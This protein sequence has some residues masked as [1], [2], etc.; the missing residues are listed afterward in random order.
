M[1]N[2]DMDIIQK[3]VL[4]SMQTQ[5][6]NYIRGKIEN[7]DW[8]LDSKIPS[9]REL[10]EKMDISRTTVRNAI[11]ALTNRGLFERKIGQ[12]TFVRKQLSRQENPRMDHGTLGFVICK[13][14]SQRKPL[15]SEAFY[16]DVFTGV[17][18]ETVKAGRHLLFTYLDDNNSDEL[19]AFSGFMDKIDGL[20][21][22]E[23]R[24]PELIDRLRERNLPVV[25]IGPTSINRAVDMVT[26]DLAGGVRTAVQALIDAGHRRIGMINGPLHL[27]SARIRYLA[28]QEAMKKAGLDADDDFADDSEGW[29]PESGFQA[30]QRL[31]ARCPD[32]TALVCANDL[33]AIGSLS[34]LNRAGIKVP[35][36][37]SVIGFDDTELAR[38]ATPPLSSMRIH[39]RSMAK[40]AVRRVVELIEN[41]DLP[42][43]EIY[44]P[45]DLVVRES[46]RRLP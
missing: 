45:I 22:E 7:N 26:M 41:E 29:T 16:F 34:A 2:K 14:R 30:T 4:E 40:A 36:Q 32:L 15:A 10:S 11:Q 28:W 44:F 42:P 21:I 20:V 43:V 37:I 5:V 27:E 38:H 13:E 23:A 17:E 3:N 33:L 6:E 12:G 25:L 18:E 24:S 8:P 1:K 35:D 9:E 46:I 39:S 19:N 31:I